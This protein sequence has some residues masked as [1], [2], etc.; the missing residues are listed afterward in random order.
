MM[1]LLFVPETIFNCVKTHYCHFDFVLA[2]DVIIVV[3]VEVDDFFVVVGSSNI[4]D[5]VVVVVDP[6]ILSQ[7]WFNKMLLLLSN[8]SLRPR[9][10]S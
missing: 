9:T 8:S 5:M 6:S 2:V 3:I 4:W 7:N 1:L 10:R